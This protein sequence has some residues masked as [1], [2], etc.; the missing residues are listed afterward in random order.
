MMTRLL[1]GVLLSAF[2]MTGPACQVMAQEEP[3]EEQHGQNH[4]GGPAGEEGEMKE[5]PPAP[6]EEALQ[7]CEEKSDGDACDFTGM[8]DEAIKGTC[9][10]PTGTELACIPAG[11]DR[12]P[13][14]GQLPQGQGG[15]E[16]VR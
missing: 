4:E 9:H 2:L 12:H 8:H 3:M 5:R 14:Q 1:T 13:P 15:H 7:A 16:R 11:L 10:A 6:P